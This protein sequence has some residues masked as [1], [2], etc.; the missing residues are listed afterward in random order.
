M[1]E[2]YLLLFLLLCAWILIKVV[3]DPKLI[4][5]YPFFL[6]CMFSIF[7]VPQAIGLVINPHLVPQGS[8]SAIFLMCFLCLL[9]AI[10]G[11][12]YGSYFN[13]VKVFNNDLKLD[14]VVHIALVYTLLGWLFLFL[15]NNNPASRQRGNWSGILTIYVTFYQV[16]NIAFAIFIFLFIRER[17]RFFTAFRTRAST[18][19]EGFVQVDA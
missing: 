18:F 8:M 17:K 16:I 1:A 19:F 14:R 2:F 15:I 13:V 4:Y 5:Q 9:M 6:G 11:Y 12:N 7:L 10:M 3:I